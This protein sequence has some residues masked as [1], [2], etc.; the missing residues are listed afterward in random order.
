MSYLVTTNGLGC[1]VA[2][3]VPPAPRYRLIAYAQGGC[4]CHR[5]VPRIGWCLFPPGEAMPEAIERALCA[6]LAIPY[7]P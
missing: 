6:A 1:R 7:A 5:Y 3:T 4:C 2:E